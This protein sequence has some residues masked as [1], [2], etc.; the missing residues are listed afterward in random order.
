MS[1]GKPKYINQLM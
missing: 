1:Q